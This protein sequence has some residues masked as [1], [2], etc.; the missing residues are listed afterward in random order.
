MHGKIA[1]ITGASRG[2]G[3]ATAVELA[4]RGAHVVLVARSQAG[5]EETDDAVRAT[6]GTATLLPLDLCD[7]AQVDLIAP[8]LFQRFG[9]LDIMVSNAGEIGT[10]TPVPH[11]D[12]REW[13]AML[14]I[15]LE[16]PLR[17]IRGCA[18]LLLAAP[19]GRAVFVTSSMA[20][21]PDAYWGHYAAS[22]AAARALVLTWAGET[23]RTELRVNLFDPGPMATRIRMRAFPGEDRSLLPHPARI[24]PALAALCL[25]EETRHGEI[26]RFETA[27]IGA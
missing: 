9:R 27:K 1:L 2:L 16:A 12:L 3:A 25:P 7:G 13:A 15:N 21:A 11:I 4:R 10:L 6:G 17:L 24:A 19:I 14:A 18:P 20:T 26:V 5:L 8:S 23:R 22:Q